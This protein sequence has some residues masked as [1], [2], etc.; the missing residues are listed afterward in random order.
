MTSLSFRENSLAS[1]AMSLPF[2]NA[3]DLYLLMGPAGCGKSS[4][5]M[6]LSAITGWRTIEGDDLHP[7]ENIRKMEAGVPLSNANRMPWLSAICDTVNAMPDDPI[8]LACSALN[9][10]VRSYLKGN[11]RRPIVPVI[12]HV[13]PDEL[14]RRINAR[15]DHFMPASLLESQ[16]AAFEPPKEAI[17]VDANQPMDIVCAEV[18]QRLN[19]HR[20]N[21]GHQKPADP[22]Q[23]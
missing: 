5:M 16:L 18:L 3:S 23:R 7:A 19:Q 4:V 6:S 1:F 10:E 14:H 20:Q 12:L 22:H 11:I 8:L 2:E 17:F 9:R 13:V 21:Q 15:K